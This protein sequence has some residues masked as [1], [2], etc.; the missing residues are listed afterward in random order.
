[1]I[2]LLLQAEQALSLRLLDQAEQLY[3]RTLAADPRNAI[4][5]VGLGR[6][7]LERGDD[8]R[9]YALARRALEID[10]AN[11]SADRLARRLAEVMTVGGRPLPSEAEIAAIAIVAGPPAADAASTDRPSEAP[12]EGDAAEARPPESGAAA[13]ASDARGAGSPPPP[14][15]R[16]GILGRIFRPR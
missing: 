15:R 1:M 5:I 9:A 12:A 2:E 6:V 11:A 3:G 14:P 8:G 16:R 10:P 7:A 4:A 13:P